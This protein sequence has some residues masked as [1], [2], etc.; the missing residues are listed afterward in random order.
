MEPTAYCSKCK[1]QTQTQNVTF[2]TSVK[3]QPMMKGHCLVCGTFKSTFLRGK[4]NKT[5]ENGFSEPDS[6]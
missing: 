3:N 6:K 4:R 5:E 1:T 2:T